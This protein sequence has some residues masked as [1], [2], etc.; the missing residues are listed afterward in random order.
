MIKTGIVISVMNKRAGIM[1]ESGEFVYIKTNKQLPNVGEI[2]TG[3]LFRKNLS[4]YKYAITAASLMIIFASS[5]FAKAYY[6]PV[7]TIV[8]SINPSVS[9]E[10]NK[11]NK[12]ISSK[13]LNSDGSILLNNIKLKNKSIDVSLELLVKEAKT[14]HFINDKYISD[15][16]TISVDIKS[17]KD[18]TIDISDFK[19]IIDSN[20][21][22]VVINTSSNNNKSIDITVNNKKINDSNL[23]PNNK[24][25]ESLNEKSDIKINP[26]KKPS[27]NGNPKISESTSS[28][29][30]DKLNIDNKTTVTKKN[31]IKKDDSLDKQ[32]PKDT[33]N[34][35]NTNSSSPT[36]EKPDASS[37]IK[38]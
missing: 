7:T 33:K 20:K 35:K 14:E 28:E 16:K 38:K 27:V 15:K 36:T 1:T 12:I 30:K 21:L 29:I 6:T 5:A 22:A 8:L 26:P 3:E 23:I 4:L 18:N 37:K 10:A 9:L 31:N 13:A 19:N 11:W 34:N 2:Y 25:K 17:S 32:K 24:E